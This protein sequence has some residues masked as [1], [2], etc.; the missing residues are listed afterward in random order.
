MM[1]SSLKHRSEVKRTARVIVNC[2]VGMRLLVGV[3]P[4]QAMEFTFGSPD[5]QPQQGTIVATGEIMPGDD[6][7]LHKM[8]AAL[9][10]KTVLAG[11]ALNS[12]G[13]NYLEGVRLAASIRNTGLDTVVFG[14]CASA[15]FLMFAA[16]TNRAVFEGAN[17]GVHSASLRG[18]ENTET[19][20]VTTQ[21]ARKLSDMGVPSTIV[22]KV[23]TTPADDIAWLTPEDLAAMKVAVIPH[24]EVS[25]HQPGSALRP[26]IAVAASARPANPVPTV[27][28]ASSQSASAAPG[29]SVMP[30]QAF[31]DGRKARVDYEA[32]FNGLSGDMRTG[33]LWWAGVRHHQNTGQPVTC[34]PGVSLWMIGCKQAETILTPNDNRRRADPDFKTGWNSL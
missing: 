15:C 6:E 20:A 5:G 27:P 9:P 24:E 8:V 10:A 11:V 34:E 18:V 16:G 25:T 17:V 13:G 14:S 21:M 22:G 1:C 23:V 33:A 30:S 31:L 29:P 3:A 19:Q 26:G 7:K 4:A 28:A 2:V 12:A 32:W